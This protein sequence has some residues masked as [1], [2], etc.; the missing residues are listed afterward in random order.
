M[1]G[2]RI[3][4][5][6][7]QRPAVHDDAAAAPRL[8]VLRRWP[9][10]WGS[11]T[12]IWS[13]RSARW[14]SK[15]ANHMSHI[16]AADVDRI[17][18]ALDREPA[19]EPG[20]GA[21]ERHR[22]SGRR[23]KSRP[24]L[25]P[26][27]AA[28]S[29]SAPAAPATSSS[30]PIVRQR[31]VVEPAPAPARPETAASAA[32]AAPRAAGRVAAR[33]RRRA[34][35]DPR[36]RRAAPSTRALDA[37]VVEAPSAPSGERPARGR[38]DHR[39][40]PRRSTRV[41]PSR[42]VPPRRKGSRRLPPPPRGGD[43]ARNHSLK[44]VIRQ[45]SSPVVTGSAATGAFISLPGMPPRGESGVPKIEIQGYRDEELRRLGR[46]GLINRAPAGRDRYG[47]PA[48]GAPGQRPG[49]PPRKKVAAA[50]KKIKKT[51]ITTP[52]EHK[53]VVRMGE[54]IAVSDLAQKMGI[55]GKEVIKKLW[56][57]GMM[58]V[59]INQ[60]IDLDT[61]TLIA[62]EFGYQIEST[63]FNEDEVIADAETQ[64]A[65]RTWCRARRWSPSWVTSTTARRRCWT[66]S[67][68]PTSPRAR[69]AASPST[70][71]PTR[72]TR[73]VATSSS[74]TPPATRPSRPCARA[75]HR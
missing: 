6:F 34:D 5:A 42:R 41:R 4:T 3:R 22:H 48:F 27:P 8:R 40:G 31:I 30:T 18:R 58:G 49:A 16:E 69:R 33:G 47:R 71:V 70:S 74:W 26:K 17:R 65:P 44:P 36:P 28:A 10:S 50:G 61:A 15:F 39:F 32:P 43:A 63:A 54:T 37:G 62:T 59:N 64:D 57:L 73:T 19:G 21:A 7:G 14:G 38:A 60:D 29:A 20:R 9:R 2:K 55:K 12:A 13:A 1:I 23:S 51:E 75:A 46:T 53:R 35:R 52:A 11:R 25:P 45:I 66:P 67:A 24:P 56:A 68:R 72:S